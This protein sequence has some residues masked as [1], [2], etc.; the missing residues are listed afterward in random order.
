MRFSATTLRWSLPSN[1]IPLL[2][3]CIQK[4]LWGSV[5]TLAHTKTCVHTFFS[6]F[7]FLFC[8]SKPVWIYFSQKSSK[9]LGV[10]CTRRCKLDACTRLYL[11]VISFPKITLLVVQCCG[12]AFVLHIALNLFSMRGNTSSIWQYDKKVASCPPNLMYQKKSAVQ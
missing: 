8:K 9:K 2:S 1:F 10:P 7:L 12:V 4:S 6:A 5:F 3:K 11:L